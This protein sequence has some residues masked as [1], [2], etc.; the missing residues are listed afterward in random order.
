MF[1]VV[2]NILAK[3]R[4]IA[5]EIGP[6]EVRAM[7]AEAAKRAQQRL[8]GGQFGQVYETGPEL[9][10]KEITLEKKQNLLNEINMQVKAAELGIAPRIVEASLMAPRIGGKTVTLEPGI[11]PNMRGEIVM[12]DLR[13]NYVPLGV[14]T[15]D[16][17]G[18][19]KSPDFTGGPV[20]GR[21]IETNPQL[22]NKQVEKAKLDTH[23]QLAQLALKNISLN[24]RHSENIFVHKM[25]GRPMQID[26]GLS[27]QITTPKQKAAVLVNHVKNGLQTAGLNEEAFILNGIVADLLDK[28]PEM[29]LDIAK[30]GLSRLQK[31]KTP[32]KPEKYVRAIDPERF[33]KGAQTPT[34][35]DSEFPW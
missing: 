26:F 31:I 19:Y 34:S 20:P 22:T 24:D 16:P 33:L 32:I 10:T 11:N 12:Q 6:E 35:L 2:K 21:Y 8:G 1:S 5:S 4:P 27:E 3:K 13:S 15:G 25:T 14:N 7:A 23:K 30:Q 29:A 17:D 9:V 28:N 18:H